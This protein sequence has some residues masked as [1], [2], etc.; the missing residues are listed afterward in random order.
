MTR[1]RAITLRIGWQLRAQRSDTLQCLG[2][3]GEFYLG[4]DVC[5]LTHLH[6]LSGVCILPWAFILLKRRF[7]PWFIYSHSDRSWYQ[8][9]QG[10]TKRFICFASLFNNWQPDDASA[11]NMAESAQS[12]GVLHIP[13]PPLHSAGWGNP[14]IDI[15]PCIL[16]IVSNCPVCVSHRY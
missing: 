12:S 6:E 11:S 16:R 9:R 14:M 10:W 8:S 5:F 15:S 13:A 4:F 2:E 3:G 1:I 7:I